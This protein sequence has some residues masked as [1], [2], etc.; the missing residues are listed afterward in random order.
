MG[1]S[2]RIISQCLTELRVGMIESDDR[3]ITV[4]SQQQINESMESLI[5]HFKL[6]TEGY[7]VPGGETDAVE[8][9][10]GRNEH[11]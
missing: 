8:A 5:H 9:P 4:H 11:S 6:Y 2:L 1:Q 10:K 7:P 3:K